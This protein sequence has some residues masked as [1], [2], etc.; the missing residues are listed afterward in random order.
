MK[1]LFTVVTLISIIL[2]QNSFTASAKTSEGTAAGHNGSIT[3]KV[4]FDDN[5]VIKAVDVVNHIETEGI[6]DRAISEIGQR[7]IK[8]Q[9]TKVDAMSGATFTSR[10]IMNAVQNAI[11][12]AGFNADDYKKDIPVPQKES[13]T[14]NTDIVVI[15]GG[16]AGLSAGTH[17]AESGADVLIVEKQSQVGGSALFAA[18]IMNVAG[19]SV[20]RDNGVFDSPENNVIALANNSSP[21]FTNEPKFTLIMHRGAV[22]MIDELR[23]RGLEF[24]EYLPARSRI[25]VIGPAMYHGGNTLVK[26]WKKNYEAAGGKT[27]LDTKVTELIFNEDKSVTGVKAESKT[28]IFT[29]NAKKV[30]LATGGYS[31]NMKLVAELTP[32]YAGIFPRDN[33]GATGDGIKLAES[34]GG[35]LHAVNAGYQFF[36]IDTKRMIDLPTLPMFS[37]AIMINKKGERF[38]NESLPF[39]ISAQAL[40]SQGDI[41]W[42]VFD[43]TARAMHKPIE[44]YFD[45]GLVTE[46]ESI[47]ELSEK[48]KTPNLEQTIER[49]NLMTEK[50]IDEDFGRT[51]NL[52]GVSGEHYYAIGARPAIYVSFGGIKIDEGGHVLRKDGSIINGLF[53]AGEVTGSMEAQEGRAYTSGLAQ[54]MVFGKIAA[55]NAVFELKNSAFEK[56]MK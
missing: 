56:E 30:I 45:L 10:G 20:Q 15:G 16:I 49:Y 54:A 36:C 25:H 28:A 22:D 9:S 53:A 51:V 34:A 55:G 37:S 21:F 27:L 23:G 46:A 17:A 43:D 8:A 32:D 29:I 48:I 12:A 3:V 11:T 18:G 19:S 50:G 13:V 52:K 33:S 14:I 40:R 5:A 39:T 38:V 24:V 35:Y 42:F 6:S 47:K 1:K 2:L 7:I 44:H 4:E 31:Y 41:G 26:L